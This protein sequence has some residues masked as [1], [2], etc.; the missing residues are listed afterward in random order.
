MQWKSKTLFK[1]ICFHLVS[2]WL[3]WS[4]GAVPAPF[5]PGW[6]QCW[7]L[8]PTRDPEEPEL[9]HNHT[10]TADAWQVVPIPNETK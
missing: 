1:L 7:S 6:K 9:F 10:E 5:I 4:L 2:P 3:L 8:L